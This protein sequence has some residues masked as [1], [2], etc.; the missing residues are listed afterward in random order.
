[1]P[2]LELLPCPFCGEQPKVL[3]STHEILCAGQD[4]FGPVTTAGN[5]ETAS[6]QWNKRAPSFAAA[7]YDG[8]AT[9]FIER[10][11]ARAICIAMPD[12][13]W[14][15]FVLGEIDK[16]KVY[17]IADV[18]ALTIGSHSSHVRGNEK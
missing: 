14:A 5:L 8:A 10:Q 4:C 17:T 11:D 6:I 3:W 16:L 1:M 2:N 15:K 13:K 7:N 9:L 12:L 18:A